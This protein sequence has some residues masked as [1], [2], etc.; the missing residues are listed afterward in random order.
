MK[1][2]RSVP[3]AVFFG[4]AGR[5]VLPLPFCLGVDRGHV[6]DG[7]TRNPRMV[8]TMAGTIGP[9]AVTSASW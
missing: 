9:V 1:P 6:H 2:P 8:A 3:A 7:G 5:P 4:A